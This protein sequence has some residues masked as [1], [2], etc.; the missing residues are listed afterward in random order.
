[1]KKR[2]LAQSCATGAL[3]LGAAGALSGCAGDTTGSGLSH[4]AAAAAPTTAA[5]TAAAKAPSTTQPSTKAQATPPP[6]VYA[7]PTAAATSDGYQDSSDQLGV[8]ACATGQLSVRY[9]AGD[10]GLGHRSAILVFTDDGAACTLYGYPGAGVT[11][12]PGQ[13][14]LNARRSLSGYLG[15]T[16]NVSTVTLEN[17]G[18][19]S[20][21]LE[22]D[23]APQDGQTTP[24][25]AD[26]PG[27]DGG[28]LLVTPPNTT[29]ATAF[30]APGDLCSDFYVHPVV[31][32]TSGVTSD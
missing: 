16:T 5:T 29:I 6:T 7:N 15:G 10:V 14:V 12:R 19:A 13:V 2:V 18:Y 26:C 20:A 4:T 3:I 28:E 23:A 17:G 32:G 9:V 22:W 25:G 21:L 27:M 30:P 31:P 1:M 8:P 11:D 24:V